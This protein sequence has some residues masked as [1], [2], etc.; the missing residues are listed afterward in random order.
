M[1]QTQFF[2]RSHNIKRSFYSYQTSCCVFYTVNIKTL[3]KQI[4]VNKNNNNFFFKNDT[5]AQTP[6]TDFLHTKIWMSIF[7]YN[8]Q[9]II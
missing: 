6:N 1:F 3:T 4:Q 2:S 9:R 7:S 8:L 5:L